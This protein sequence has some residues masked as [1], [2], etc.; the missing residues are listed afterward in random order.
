M[1]SDSGDL[2]EA[3]NALLVE[4]RQQQFSGQI[5]ASKRQPTLDSSERANILTGVWF[6]LKVARNGRR[7]SVIMYAEAWSLTNRRFG[8]ALMNA[9]RTLKFDKTQSRLELSAERVPFFHFLEALAT[10][11]PHHGSTKLLATRLTS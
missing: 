1:N 3:T 5:F 2:D 4:S 7:M 9:T 6:E 10:V 11:K 8:W